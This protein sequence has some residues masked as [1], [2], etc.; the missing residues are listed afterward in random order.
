MPRGA[1]LQPWYLKRPDVAGDGGGIQVKWSRV[2]LFICL[3]YLLRCAVLFF[4]LGSL[5]HIWSTAGM[6]EPVAMVIDN[7]PTAHMGKKSTSMNV[8]SPL[9]THRTG[10]QPAR[11]LPLFQGSGSSSLSSVR[12]C[13]CVYVCIVSLLLPL[14]VS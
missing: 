1:P 9:S 7:G 4:L 5:G 10:T 14:W 2:F 6:S 12:V 8:H 11:R 13:V 3:C